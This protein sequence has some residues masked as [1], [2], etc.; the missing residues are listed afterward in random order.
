MA[1][2]S[3]NRQIDSRTCFYVHC[4]LVQPTVICEPIIR[5]PT[6]YTPNYAR[7]RRDKF[8]RQQLENMPVNT[9]T[10]SH[11][12]RNNCCVITCALKILYLA[13]FCDQ[14]V[15]GIG[16]SANWPCKFEI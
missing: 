4:F 10:K 7:K 15:L 16:A 3:H 5:R 13:R 8:V 14:R 11:T 9:R 12:E 2:C 6:A 1:P